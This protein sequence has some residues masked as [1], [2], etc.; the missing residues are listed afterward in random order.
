VYYASVV[1]ISRVQM[2]HSDSVNSKIH[3]F[4]YFLLSHCLHNGNV[5]ELCHV[6]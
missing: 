5:Y 3:S 1:A 4:K 2:I 6:G